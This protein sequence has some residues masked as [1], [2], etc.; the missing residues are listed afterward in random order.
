MYNK[1]EEFWG[2]SSKY[3]QF[4]RS[5][6]DFWGD[7]SKLRRFEDFWGGVATLLSLKLFGNSWGNS[8]ITCLFLI[9]MLCFTSGERKICSII[10]CYELDCLQNIL[11]LFMSLLTALI[12]K[13]GHILSGIYFI[14]LKNVLDLTWNVFNTEFEPQWNV[15]ESGY[16]VKQI[17]VLFCK[18]VTLILG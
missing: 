10:K 7:F 1:I 13:N 9:T 15:Q 18:L 4:W 16:Q 17:L 6:E 2:G 3:C 8:N 11:F 14:F 12:V 5:F